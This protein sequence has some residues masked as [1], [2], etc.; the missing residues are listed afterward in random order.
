MVDQNDDISAPSQKAGP[1]PSWKQ[2]VRD[3]PKERLG[4]IFA[5]LMTCIFLA[6]IDQVR[7]FFR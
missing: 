3:T 5:G 1:A 6:A 7:H 2:E 4:I